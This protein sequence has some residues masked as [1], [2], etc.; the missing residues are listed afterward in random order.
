MLLGNHFP[1]TVNSVFIYIGHYNSL[2]FIFKL[3]AIAYRSESHRSAASHNQDI[4]V[5][6]G[7]HGM[8]VIFLVR[9]VIGMV[10]AD[11]TAHR[12]AERCL[13]IAFA[14]IA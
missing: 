6:F 5:R 4:A 7:S 11:N 3:Y 13:E 9:M 8:L 14:V 12:F 1:C 10:P 2:R